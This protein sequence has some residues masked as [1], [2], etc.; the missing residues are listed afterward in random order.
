MFFTSDCASGATG[1]ASGWFSIAPSGRP[2][3]ITVRTGA[4]RDGIDVDLAADGAIS[5]TAV[6]P[7]GSPVAGVCVTAVPVAAGPAP[8]A[9]AAVTGV[10]GSYV[11]GFLTPGTYRVRFASGCGAAATQ[12]GGGGPRD[13]P[14]GPCW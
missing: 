4:S 13:R 9:T 7:G 5:G 1:F 12:R 11:I 2:R 8:V 6:G 10:E 3:G 14:A